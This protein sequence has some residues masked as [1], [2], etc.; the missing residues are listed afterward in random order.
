MRKREPET[1][2]QGS[3]QATAGGEESRARALALGDA[4]DRV[5]GKLR[6]IHPDYTYQPIG[7]P[8]EATAIRGG[9]VH[10]SSPTGPN[11]SCQSGSDRSQSGPN[12]TNLGMT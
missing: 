5:A 12:A 8:E 6:A 11:G 9:P 4:I 3:E 10:E 7:G 1:Q 2:K